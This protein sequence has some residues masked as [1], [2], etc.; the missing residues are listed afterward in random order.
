MLFMWSWVE[1]RL[2]DRRARMSGQGMVEYA[3][4]LVLVAVAVV[5]VLA[6]MGNRISDTFQHIV[7]CLDVTG[8]SCSTPTTPTTPAG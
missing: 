7:K 4:I 5:A 3:L 6:T 1:C 2:A 8:Q